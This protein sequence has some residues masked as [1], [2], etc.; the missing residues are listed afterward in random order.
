MRMSE[1]SNMY[2]Q[3]VL[4]ATKFITPSHTIFAV[5]WEFRDQ[6]VYIS[7]QVFLSVLLYMQKN[8]NKLTLT[9]NCNKQLKHNP[10]RPS[11]SSRQV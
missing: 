5:R 8:E 11:N 4:Q 7:W 10:H 6:N 9:A 2:M 3:Y 1:S